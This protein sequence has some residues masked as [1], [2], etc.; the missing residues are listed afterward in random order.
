MRRKKMIKPDIR[1]DFKK[2]TIKQI[3]ACYFLFETM[4]QKDH[5]FKNE[6]ERFY[7]LFQDAFADV[8]KNPDNFKKLQDLERNGGTKIAE[9]TATLED[10]DIIQGIYL[11]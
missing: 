6:E 8:Y 9:G 4:K 1:P 7:T 2:S 11:L 10:C 5:P 3:C